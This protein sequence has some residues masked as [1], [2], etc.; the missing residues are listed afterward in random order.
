MQKNFLAYLNLL[1]QQFEAVSPSSVKWIIRYH[2][3]LYGLEIFQFGKLK[4]SLAT[5]FSIQG[6]FQHILQ[7][8]VMQRKSNFSLLC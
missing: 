3:S 6:Q 5:L 1:L 8:K 7:E 2:Q 4:S